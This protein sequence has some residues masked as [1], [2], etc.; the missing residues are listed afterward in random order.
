MKRSPRLT[1]SAAQSELAAA[2][3]KLRADLE[4]PDGF[5]AEVDAE[6]RTAAAQPLDT[7]VDDLREIEFCTIDPEGTT[8]LDQALHLTREGDGM[9]VRYAIAD[10]PWFV[11]PQGAVD[12]EARRRGQTLYAPDERAPLHPAVLSEDAASLLPDQDRQA[13]VWDFHLDSSVEVRSVEL[14]RAVVRSRKQWS[15]EGA[16]QAVEDGTAPESL[17]LLLPFGEGR[18]QLEAA[19][20]GASLS[21]PD[22][23]VVLTDRGYLI[24]RRQSLPIE[25]ANAQLSLMTGM[26]AAR[27]MLRGNVGILRTMPA[28]EQAAVDEF[29]HQTKALG[30]PWKSTV[31]YGDY[32]RGLDRTQPAGLAVLQAATALFRGAGYEAF[33]GTAPEQP[34]QAAIAAPYAHVTAPLRR[35]VDRFGLTVCLAVQQDQQV[36]QWAREAL[37]ELPKIMATSDELASRLDSGALN[38]VEAALLASRSDETFQAV[39][40]SRKN[41]H[42]RI[43]LTDPAVTAGING[44]GEPGDELAVRLVSADISTGEVSFEP[45]PDN[46][47]TPDNHR[48]SDNQ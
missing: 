48:F 35:L 47:R 4:V 16:Q 14:T 37:P 15:Y 31:S 13:F 8:D 40:L 24:E 3:A 36:P 44:V 25:E 23:E 32:L 45:A 33:D 38:R 22:G 26:A 20:G 18:Q 29:R 19:R 41:D 2:L 42:R 30:L 34:L 11:E 5:P 12:V 27:L 17:Q 46:P 43:Q 39:V 10:V 21:L 6:A 7:S 28:A 9:R 1:R